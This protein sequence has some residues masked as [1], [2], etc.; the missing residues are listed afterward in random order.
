M[1]NGKKH[2]VSSCNYEEFCVPWEVRI[3]QG[4]AK[5]KAGGPAHLG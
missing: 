4:S 3:S 2:M 1:W 5:D